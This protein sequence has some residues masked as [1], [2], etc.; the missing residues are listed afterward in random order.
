MLPVKGGKLILDRIKS[1][2]LDVGWGG[3]IQTPSVLAGEMVNL[4]SG[5]SKPLDVS[6]GAP[7]LKDLSIHHHSDGYFLFVA[8]S[9]LP[10]KARTALATRIGAIVADPSTQAGRL[11][12]TSFG[13]A[14]VIQGEELDMYLTNHLETSKALHATASTQ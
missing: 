1:A 10:E 8:P 5:L 4:A 6:P 13:G 14:K 7:L 3:G 9:A 2:E 11:V 12:A